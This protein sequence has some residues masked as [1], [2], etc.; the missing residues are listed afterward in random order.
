MP[1]RGA[2]LSLSLALPLLLCAVAASQSLA[3]PPSHGLA[4]L[5]RGRRDL[6]KVA[7]TF[8]GGSGAGDTALILDTLA[9]RQVTATFFLTGEFIQRNP[10]LVRRIVTAGHEVGNHMWSHLHLTA[11]DRV[12]RHDTLPG[13]DAA[14]V[15][16]ELA[17]TEAAFAAVA[18]RRM[19]PLWRAPYGEVNADIAAWAGDDGWRHIGWSREERG[20]GT[21]D[22]LDWVADR[23]A[24]IYLTSARI[25]ARILAFDAAGSGL[26]GGIVL[27]HL[28]ARSEDPLAARLDSLIDT[29]R[30]RGYALATVGELQ[31]D[32]EP[33]LAVA[34]IR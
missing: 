1:R 8:D 30:A 19:A 32:L 33:P 21:L 29:L 3:Q 2:R 27:M 5:E 7:L 18:G 28:C 22:S 26:S 24:R 15:R 34:T 12:R 11:W 20:A 16:R 17:A 23:S 31:R 10:D 13:V 9:S 6:R 4:G 25:V 14:L